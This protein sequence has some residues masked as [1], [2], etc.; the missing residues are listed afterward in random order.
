MRTVKLPSHWLRR[1][2]RLLL[3]CLAFQNVA[4][5]AHACPVQTMPAAGATLRHCVDGA[6]AASTAMTDSALCAQHC[7][8]ERATGAGHADLHVPLAWLPELPPMAVADRQSRP[9]ACRAT[10]AVA[11]PPPIRTRYCSLLI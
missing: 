7:A 3:L 2:C 10:A 4:V 1:I 11:P 8:P 5:A 6:T 9:P